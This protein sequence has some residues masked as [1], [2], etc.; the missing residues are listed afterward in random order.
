MINQRD[1]LSDTR[2]GQLAA[3]A[4]C[5]RKAGARTHQEPPDPLRPPFE[6]DCHRIVGSAA[7]RR[8]QRKTQ[9]F[10][11][12]QDDHARTR[13]THTLEAAWLG[14]LLALQLSANAALAEAIVLAHDLGHPPFGHAGEK[15]LDHAMEAHGGFNHNEH[16]LRIVTF[17]EHPFPPFRGLNLTRATCAGLATHET[18]FDAPADSGQQVGPGVEAQIASLAD[19]VAYNSHDLE[20]AIGAKIVTPPM[21]A[22]LSLWR[23]AYDDVSDM[24]AG[25]SSIHAIRRVVLDRLINLVLADV[26]DTSRRRL[27]DMTSPQ[28]VCS[29]SAAVVGPSPVMEGHL[30]QLEAFLDGHVYRH[31]A[32]STTDAQ[33]RALVM[34]L[35]RLMVDDPTLMPERFASRVDTQGCQRV[36]CDYIA[37]MTDRY[38]IE[39]HE[40]L[41]PLS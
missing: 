7:F 28:Q 3:Y 40:R 32:V 22:D 6:L 8:L 19:R 4:T 15:A 10:V 30:A 2:C 21:L 33:G 17:L 34:T 41:V 13:L 31:P 38:C 37:G 23:Q 25:A 1:S 16:S 9:V 35:F 27:A 12:L 26:V 11:S 36:V 24:V 18:R 39:Q 20:D 5:E 29:A 14:R